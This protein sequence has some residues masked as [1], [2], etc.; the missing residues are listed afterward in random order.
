MTYPKLPHSVMTM[1]GP[2]PVRLVK[3]WKDESAWGMWHRDR[4]T[5][6]IDARQ[7]PELQWSTFFHEVTHC[8]LDD[9][10]LANIL[11]EPQQEALCDAMATARMRERF[12]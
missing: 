8:A 9:S 4:R 7:T 12:G 11:T 2:V 10:G 1:L 6:E 5:I 3:D